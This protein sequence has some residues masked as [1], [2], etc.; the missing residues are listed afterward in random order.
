MKKIL[1]IIFVLLGLGIV[2]AVVTRER[3]VLRDISLENVKRRFFR[4]EV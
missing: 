2:S 1:K 3:K 4:K